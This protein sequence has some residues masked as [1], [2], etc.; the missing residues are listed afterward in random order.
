MIALRED[1][2]VSA[3]KRGELDHRRPL[4]VCPQRL[5]RDVPL[6]RNAPDDRV[7]DAERPRDDPVRSVGTDE[8]PRAHRLA[9][10]PG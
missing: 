4:E 3:G 9:A 2:A 7:V 8:H 10:D 5:E 6:E 1:P